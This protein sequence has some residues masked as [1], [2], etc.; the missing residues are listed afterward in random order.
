MQGWDKACGCGCRRYPAIKWQPCALRFVKNGIQM[1]LNTAAGTQE[2]YSRG[3]LYC[4]ENVQLCFPWNL[5]CFGWFFSMSVHLS[6]F[7]HT[8]KASFWIP[9]LKE[10]VPVHTA[11]WGHKFRVSLS[12]MGSSEGWILLGS[13]QTPLTQCSQE[14]SNLPWGSTTWE[15]QE[16]NILHACITWKSFCRW[17]SQCNRAM[18]DM[19]EQTSSSSLE[20]QCLWILLLRRSF[21]RVFWKQAQ[22]STHLSL[23]DCWSCS[24]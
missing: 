7:R 10:W 13:A 24:S 3:F 21:T 19:T 14:V 20:V 16:P 5:T 8:E 11:L 17:L 9:L 6:P 1:L 4:T 12:P 2:R 22:I 18:C 15:R 23:C